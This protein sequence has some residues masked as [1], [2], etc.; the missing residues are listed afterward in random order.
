MKKSIL[1]FICLFLV[2]PSQ[3]GIIYVDAN[4]PDNND[5]SS[6]SHAYKYLQDA[7]ADANSSGDVNEI[8]VAQGVYTPDS[9]SDDPNG[10]GDRE[11]TFQLINGLTI[12]GGY[13]GFG[14]PDPNARDIE[15]YETILN[16]DLNSDDIQ[17]TNPADM[18][19]EP[20]RYDNSENVVTGSDTDA[21][22]VLD[23]FTITAGYNGQLGAGMY[24]QDGS[25]TVTNCT[26]TWNC[27]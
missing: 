18:W 19:S 14:E 16:G 5:G 20:S 15:L 8:W 9:N 11:A 12:K 23:G 1:A 7:L 25:P 2:V 3:A 21:N 24:N 17:L 6:W 26:F 4:T 13:A 10:S 27:A 22:A